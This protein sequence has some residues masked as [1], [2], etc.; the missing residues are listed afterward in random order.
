MSILLLMVIL[1]AAIGVHRILTFEDLFYSWRRWAVRRPWT[2]PISCSACNPVWIALVLTIIALVVPEP[3]RW[4]I[5]VPFA[6]YPAVRIFD[7]YSG[8]IIGPPPKGSPLAADPIT[9][10]KLVQTGSSS[11]CSSC[12]GAPATSAPPSPALRA[13][14]KEHDDNRSYERR[15]VLFT[16]FADLHPSYSLTTAVFDQARILARNPKHRVQVWVLTVCGLEGAPTDLPPNVIIRRCVP[17]IPLP[18]DTTDPKAEELL[19]GQLRPHLMLLGNAT[20]ITHDLLFVRDYVTV[21]ATIHHHLGTIPGFRWFHVCHSAPALSRPDQGTDIR[22]RTNLPDGHLLISLAESHRRGLAAYYGTTED[23]VRVAP[24]ARD[25]RS[26]LSASADVA[27]LIERH[28]LL[29]ASVV[30]I[31]PLS[32][33][34]AK[35]KGIATIIR[36]FAE[37]AKTQAV[38]LVVPN[39]H[40]NGHQDVLAELRGIAREAGLADDAL[41]FVSESL[42][43]RAAYGLT[44]AEMHVLFQCSNLFLFPSISE[45]CSMSVLEAA[46]NGCLLVLNE[47]LPSLFD[48][49]PRSQCLAYP[50]GSIHQTVPLDLQ[51]TPA[52]VAK[53]VMTLLTESSAQLTKRS[54]MR[55][56]SFAAV[57]RLLLKALH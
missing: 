42:P 45:A 18:I 44:Q 32:T 25:L 51:P 30:Q 47:S 37:L 38:R 46:L 49:I 11:G 55:T 40:A 22:Y 53:T 5:L 54:V 10:S 34:R 13:L 6:V 1:L 19:A 33:P 17:P 35:D 57:E 36:V 26:L 52:R 14:A 4:G 16:W 56:H 29:E 21:A 9:P 7:H 15:F 24:N 28:Q 2:K 12:G 23:R 39:A 3:W 27:S 31:L 8:R 50:W 48:I 41:I 20:I 43:S